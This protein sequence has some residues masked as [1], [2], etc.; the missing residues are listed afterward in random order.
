M[1]STE[2]IDFRQYW[3]AIQRRWLP[4]TAVFGSVVVLTALATILQKPV[5]EAK[6]KLLI[7]KPS[8]VTS[9]IRQGDVEQEKLSAV[10]RQSDPLNTEAE[11]IRSVP[12]ARRSIATLRLNQTPNKFLDRLKVKQIPTTDILEIFCELKHI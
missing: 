7:K 6:G 10:G 1:Q 3:L 8:N 9:A 4:A 12:I 2:H 11:I 5:Y